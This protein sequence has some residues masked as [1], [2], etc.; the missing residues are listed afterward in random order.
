MQLV[1]L[2]S[3]LLVSMYANLCVE[4]DC[5]CVGGRDGRRAFTSFADLISFSTFVLNFYMMK[6]CLKGKGVLR[7]TGNKFCI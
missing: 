4:R 2:C 5:V 1:V 3:L 6:N 7:P